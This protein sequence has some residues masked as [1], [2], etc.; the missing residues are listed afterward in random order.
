VTRKNGATV[1]DILYDRL[2]RAIDVAE[3]LGI[4]TNT[5]LDWAESG[6]LPSFK[7]GGRAVRFRRSEIAAW[8]DS[9][10]REVA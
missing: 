10:R 4:S 5:A 8:I 1:E 6:Q 7:L 9:Q 3:L 2:L